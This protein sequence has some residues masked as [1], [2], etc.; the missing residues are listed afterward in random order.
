MASS[1]TQFAIVICS[2]AAIA[3]TSSNVTEVEDADLQNG[4][5]AT[6][7]TAAAAGAIELRIQNTTSVPVEFQCPS[8]EVRRGGDWQKSGI[9][10]CV[11]TAAVSAGS[12]EQ[13]QLIL[14]DETTNLPVTLRGDGTERLRIVVGRREAGTESVASPSRRVQLLVPLQT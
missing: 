11:G 12:V 6:A 7:R 2:V 9:A 5:R 13:P 8:L 4:V 3:C 1:A 14:I 10:V